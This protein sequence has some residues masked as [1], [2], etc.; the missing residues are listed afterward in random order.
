MKRSWEKIAG[1]G[2][3][4]RRISQ[5]GIKSVYPLVT[6]KRREKVEMAIQST[7]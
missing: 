3:G 5:C 6:N 1:F 2:G 4:Y 7:R